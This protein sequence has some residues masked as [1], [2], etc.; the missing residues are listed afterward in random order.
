MSVR[1]RRA[2]DGVKDSAKNPQQP[3]S[4]HYR[5][6]QGR[7]CAPDGCPEVC[8]SKQC[9]GVA[10]RLGGPLD[11]RRNQCA[12]DGV[13]GGCD[14]NVEEPECQEEGIR[15][16]GAESARDDPV[17]QER[18]AERNHAQPADD[19]RVQRLSASCPEPGL[20]HDHRPESVL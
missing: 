13:V 19:Q 1:T 5:D 18:E 7:E 11:K 15:I 2:V 6:Q 14:D 16:G 9:P 10:G 3:S 17:K 20:E 4:S 12:A 8:R